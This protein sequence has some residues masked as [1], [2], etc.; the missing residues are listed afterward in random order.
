MGQ[1][2]PDLEKGYAMQV[3]DQN[4][5]PNAGSQIL[6]HGSRQLFRYWEGLRAER[7]CPDRSEF[8]LAK[9]VSI[10]P[11]LAIIEHSAHGTWNFR[12]AGT[13]VCD[14][15]Q[16]PVTGQDALGGFD[17]F[18]RDVVSKTFE[19][20]ALRLQPC[21]VRMR[22]V[23]TAGVVVPVEFIGLPVRD[24]ASGKVQLFSGLFALGN[25][26]SAN[27]TL[28]LRRELVSS[29]VIWTEHENGD[30]LMNKVGKKVTPFRVIEGGLSSPKQ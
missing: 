1:A 28:L 20:S 19:V 10:L 15:L 8:Q 27:R 13:V 25:S 11:N 3:N 9:M 30:L 7:A 21:L 29:R 5:S 2:R 24:Q 18:E 4:E 16:Q 22:L 23:S 12:L 17:S 6:H 14:L 26:E